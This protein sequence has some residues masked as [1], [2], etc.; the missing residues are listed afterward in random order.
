MPNLFFVTTTVVM[1]KYIRV[2]RNFV[3]WNGLGTYKFTANLLVLATAWAFFPSKH[4]AVWPIRAFVWIFFGPWVKLLDAFW[5]HTYYRTKEDLLRDG[6]PE[7]TEDMKED[8]AKRPNILDPILRSAWFHKTTLSGRIVI[9]DNLKL[10]A[11]RELL[12]GKYT[13]LIP[14]IDTSRYPSVP[15]SSSFAQPYGDGTGTRKGDYVDIPPE[16][17]KWSHAH[18]QKLTGK[19]VP[20]HVSEAEQ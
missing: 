12:F 19:M 6:I 3:N 13:E 4:L 14:A 10:I 2:L 16:D 8:I 18:G 9:E 7:T 5:I 15:D 17:K 20:I 11:F 1:C